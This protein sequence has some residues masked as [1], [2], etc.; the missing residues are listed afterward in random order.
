MTEQRRRCISR[1]GASSA[2]PRDASRPSAP[3]CSVTAAL[4]RAYPSHPCSIQDDPAYVATLVS[5]VDLCGDT[6][7]VTP[8]WPGAEFLF[9]LCDRSRTPARRVTHGTPFE[10]EPREVLA[11]PVGVVGRGLPCTGGG[12]QPATGVGQRARRA[13]HA[14]HLR[15]LD[16]FEGIDGVERLG[17]EHRFEE[18]RR[19]LRCPRRPATRRGAAES[20]PGPRRG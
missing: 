5:S 6:L 10:A 16:P 18:R 9:Q 3:A 13:A 12:E 8:C 4:I 7:V 15:E 17:R 1:P 20:L 2:R 14:H 19:S 11:K